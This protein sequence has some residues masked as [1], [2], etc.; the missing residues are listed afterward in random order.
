MKNHSLSALIGAVLLLAGCGCKDKG[1]ITVNLADKGPD[2][3]K[4]MYGVFFEEINH[5]GDGGLYAEMIQDRHFE[6]YEMPEGYFVDSAGMLRPPAVIYHTSGNV[7]QGSFRWHKDGVSAWTLVTEGGAN[8][9]CGRTKAI[10]LNNAAPTSMFMK[11]NNANGLVALQNSGFWGI[12]VKQGEN[13]KLRY[14]INSH[15]YRGS[16]TAMIVSESGEVLAENK[17]EKLKSDWN[18]YEAVLTSSG[19]DSK[20]LFRLVFDAYGAVQVD[21]VSLFPEKT[22]KGRKNGLRDDV[23]QFL[24]ELRP[25]FVRWPGGCIVEGITL[26]NRV[27]WKKTIGDPVTRPG[28]YD[29]WG[30][31]NSYGFGYAEFLQYCEDINAEGMYVCNIG[32]GCQARSG[33]AC[34]DDELQYYIDDCMDAIEYA[35]GDVSTKWGAVRAQEGHPAPYPLK[36]VEIGNEN[37]GELYDRRYDIFYKAIKAKYPQLILISNHGID[38]GVKNIEKTDMVD[39]HWYVSP[40]YFFDNTHIFDKIPRGDYKV[41][42]GEY[43]C[44]S[45]VGSGNMLAALSEAAFITGMERNSDLVTMASY[46][47][48][49]ENRNDRVW[50]VNLIWV[51]NEKVLGR[52]SYYVQK[53]FAENMPTYNLGTQLTGNQVLKQPALREGMVGFGTWDTQA[54]YKDVKITDAKGKTHDKADW[55]FMKGKWDFTDGVASQL[56]DQTMTMAL[57][58]NSPVGKKYTIEA[59]ARKTGGKEGFFIYFGMSEDG[60][61]G[62]VFNVA[63]WG[64]TKTA[65][66]SIRKGDTSSPHSEM[67]AHKLETGRW[68]DLKVVVGEKEA[69]L[70]VDGVSIVKYELEPETTRIYSVA[71]YDEA[72]GE[73]VVKVVNAEETPFTASLKLD[74]VSKVQKAGKVITLASQSPEDENSFDEPTKISPIETAY[75]G[76]AKSF[77][78]KFEPNSF[79]ILRIKASK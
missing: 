53:M 54:E 13:Y 76:F 57:W 59:K 50:S 45:Q 8:A 5:A 71:G 44:N 64:N 56:S 48:L 70:F 23:A 78:Y 52:S 28:Q 47:P 26:N 3:P 22:Y 67:V 10:P 32:L 41:Y 16:V 35:I 33:D 37:W 24:A 15:G 12:P 75:D 2:V 77:D 29:T 40:D 58:K 14:Y 9:T 19:T 79:T 46:A 69:E 66:E 74:N 43:A 18:E 36:Y 38:G 39:P 34:T 60:K 4:S 55:S 1:T 11:I 65:L 63:G 25:A 31:R 7:N 61:D 62:Y 51:D 17:V 30:Y 21:Y 20:A 73:V 49:F 27:E 6:D 72:A 68:Y 42:V